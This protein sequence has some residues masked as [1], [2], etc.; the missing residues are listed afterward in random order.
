MNVVTECPIC[1]KKASI[2]MV[3]FLVETTCPSCQFCYEPIFHFD[4]AHVIYQETGFGEWFAD[5]VINSNK[6][7][8]YEQFRQGVNDG[9]LVAMFPLVQP[10]V[11]LRGWR[12]GVFNLSV[13]LYRFGPIIASLLAC[14][15]GHS[16]WY[17]SGIVLTEFFGKSVHL[18]LRNTLQ[19]VQV[20]GF[21]LL[22][23]LVCGYFFGVF[24]WSTF[25]FVCVAWR[26]GGFFITDAMQDG[27][28]RSAL[29]SDP[30]LFAALIGTE[31]I[32]VAP[33]KQPSFMK[34]RKWRR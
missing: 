3:S 1:S 6:G 15:F 26:L 23:A 4:P 5:Y 25:G 11:I 12:K 8:S 31:K 24:H 30:N 27:M 19:Q 20:V 17:L 32:Y 2:P 34:Y 18:F 14:Y 9:K 33:A 10:F 28:A 16:A 22:I 29:Y 7:Y 13:I 21:F